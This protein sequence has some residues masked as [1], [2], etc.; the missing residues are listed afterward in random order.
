VEAWS[1]TSCHLE[2]IRAGH[3]DLASGNKLL[4]PYCIGSRGIVG[5]QRR[6]AM[7]SRT[8]EEKER[9]LELSIPTISLKAIGKKRDEAKK[10]GSSRTGAQGGR[11]RCVPDCRVWKLWLVS[12]G[13]KQA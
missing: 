5:G 6:M 11:A 1:R 7:W 4:P 10:S 3:E 8:R 2:V 12:C 13:C 9:N